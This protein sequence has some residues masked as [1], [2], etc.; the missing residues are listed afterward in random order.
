MY[1]F[2]RVQCLLYFICVFFVVCSFCI[3]H[4]KTK[5]GG[6][7][8]GRAPSRRCIELLDLARRERVG[9]VENGDE[10]ARRVARACAGSMRDS[11]YIYI[12]IYIYIYKHT[13][14]TL[15]HRQ[16]K[17]KKTTT[18]TTHTIHIYIHSVIVHA[19]MHFVLYMYAYILLCLFKCES[20][21]FYFAIK[22]K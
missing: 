16:R 12:Y 18:H 2:H 9:A 21:L 20:V 13:T 11:M 19:C 6:G 4:N 15:M 17:H 14:H 22:L 5:N 8:I 7:G 1:A 10:S 3:K